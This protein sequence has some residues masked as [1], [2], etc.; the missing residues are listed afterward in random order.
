MLILLYSMALCRVE[1]QD[2]HH[3]RIAVSE[4]ILKTEINKYL[5]IVCRT[6]LYS[7]N[8]VT[9]EYLP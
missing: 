2:S 4:D 5:K 8:E 7:P 6:F 9:Y 3:K 1:V